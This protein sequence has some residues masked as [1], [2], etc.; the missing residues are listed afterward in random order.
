LNN[1]LTLSVTL[2]GDGRQLSGT[3]RDAQND[4][5]EFGTTTER[6]SRKA[7]T[8]LTAPGRSAV[9]VSDHLRTTQR[10]A[11]AFGTEATQGGREATQAL[12]QTSQQVQ[13]TNSHFN[14]LRT[15]VGLAL[16]AFSVR[17]LAGMADGWSDMQ[18][19]VGAAIGDMSAAGDMMERITDI[20]NASY[21]PLEQTAR[22][23]ASNVS[24][25]RDL[26]RTAADTADYTESLNHMLVLTA[27]RGQQA[28][29]VQNALSR[30]MAVGRLQADGLETVL[31]NGGEVA[32]SL[33]N[34]LGVTVSQLRGLASE[35]KITGDVIASALIGSLD[36]VRERAGEMPATIEDGFVRIGTSATRL[37][38]EL[39]QAMGASEGVAG[40]LIGAA[41]LMNAAIDPLV[42]NIDNI[43]FAATA[44]AVVLAGRYVGAIAASQAALAAKNAVVATTTGALNV[45]T[46]ATTRQAAAA[47]AMAGA[48]RVAA[49][50]LALIGG[51]LGAAVIA[52][53]AIYYF[54][55]ELGLVDVVAQNTTDALEENTAAI[56]SGTAAA[57]DA[58]YDN[59]INALE[60]VSLQA[61]D[62][63]AQMTELQARQA[64]YENSHKGMSDSVTGAIDQQAQS[65]AGLWEEQVRIQTAIRQ[66]RAERENATTADRAAAVA[67]DDITVSAARSTQTTNAATEAARA[68]AAATLALTK[69]TEA[70][71][72]A[73]EALRNRLVPNRRETLQ[74]AQ[75]QNTLNLAFAMG[76]ITA[77]EYLYMIGALQTAYIEAQNDADDLATSTTNAL[78]TMEGAMEELRTNGLRRLDDGF[79]DLW[80]GAVDGSRNATDTIRRMWDQT[81]AELLHM[82]ITRPITV[83]LATSMGLGGSGQQAASGS[84]SFG[85]LPSIRG[86]MNGS[87]AIANAYRAFQGTGSS[88]AGTFGSEL[89]V[90]TEGGLRAGFDSFVNSGFGNAALGIGGGIAGGYVGTQLGSSLFGRDAGSNYGAMGGAAL[91]QAFIPIPGLGAAIGGALGGLADSLFGSGKKTFDFDFL[92]GQ[93]SYVFGDRTS[94]FG[95]SGLTALSDYKLGEQQDQLNE[96]LTA[97]AEFDNQLAAAAIPERFE[98]MKASIHGFT[99][100]G[101]EDL[102]ETRLRTLIAGSESAMADA[103]VQI[104]DPQQLADTFV[105][106]LQL[107][108]IGQ[109]LGG[110]VLGDIE[111]EI[112]RQGTAQGV[113][114][115]AN[116]MA[117]AANAAA[118]LADSTDRLNLQFD[119]TA[120][121]AIHVASA[122]QAQFGGAENL[123]AVQSAYY[124]TAFSEAERLTHQQEALNAQFAALNMSMPAS[125]VQI[126]QLIEAQDMNTNAGA[127]L[128]YELM[129]LTPALDELTTAMARQNQAIWDNIEA[130]LNAEYQS[131]LGRTASADDL[132]YWMTQIEAG[133]V[134][135]DAALQMIANSTEAAGVAA[136]GGAAGIR[137]REQLE[138]QLLQA[139][140]N[141]AALRALELATLNPANHA[142]QRRIWAIQDEQAALQEA[143]RQQQR[144]A[145]ALTA[146][147]AQLVNFGANV[148]SWLAQLRGTDAGMGTPQQQLDAADA[149]FWAQYEKALAGDRNA[150]Q[151]ITSYADRYLQAGQGM[152]ASGAGAQ[153]IRDELI[154]VMERLPGLLSAEEFLAEEFKNTIGQQTDALAS[155]FDMLKDSIHRDLYANFENIDLNLDGLIDWSE[156]RRAFEGVASDDELRRIFDKLDTDGSRTISLA[157]AQR[158]LLSAMRGIS[159]DAEGSIRSVEDFLYRAGSPSWGLRVSMSHHQDIGAVRSFGWHA[160]NEIANMATGGAYL[161]KF[162]GPTTATTA[163]AART[164]GSTTGSGSTGGSSSGAGPSTPTDAYGNPLVSSAS[165]PVANAYRSVLGRD[166]DAAGLAYWEGRYAAGLS[167]AEIRAALRGEI[168]GSHFTGLWNVPFDGYV[169]ELHR[170]EMVV[171]AK[172]ASRLRDLPAHPPSVGAMP[173]PSYPQLGNNAVLET[174]RELKREVAELRRENAQLQGESNKHLAAANNQ[175]GAAAKG[176]IGAIERGNKMLKKMEDDK[177][178]E[179]AKR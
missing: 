173:L 51:P 41:D 134:S 75:N 138:R 23:Y 54:R 83:Q 21:A 139:Q 127:Q 32:Q 52:G 53:S 111:A 1:N 18:S 161:G 73:I 7:D 129:A 5:R 44:V 164:S 74:L 140:G 118:L 154:D 2:T 151:G 158:Q 30:A 137:E 68:A 103:V 78:Y 155:E 85:G 27:T 114:D 159:A 34:H 121:G 9:T 87:G 25:L 63:M 8:A 42:D 45:L 105:R 15:T 156:F 67:L 178:L 92:Q 66:N 43:Q 56:R 20:A 143:E 19:V 65:L 95:D 70:Q 57:L 141:T 81:L 12:S 108:Q 28:E 144:Y 16:G 157:E 133:A 26:G 109:Q 77:S 14:L 4:V 17:Q 131:T 82:A 94:A 24:A 175:R 165:G 113:N 130:S 172:T 166:P 3:L 153:S 101:P 35:G 160:A 148:N 89:A 142:L 76:R 80:L 60:A 126:R 39:D 169:A 58:S 163:A 50:A 48:T 167:L 49:G 116:A 119:V 90:Q 176:Q 93:H 171:P 96:M 64:F 91:G 112:N 102:F 84:Q 162:G 146:A 22:T 128:A 40:I 72:T 69:A 47:T 122:L 135:L 31:A 61:Q 37:V 6:E 117:V 13:T 174:L 177:R 38:G 132:Y 97:M 125:I 33:A 59:L 88:Y 150:L 104:A 145:Q 123:A 99:H 115:A 71:A 136:A 62:A 149:D 120:A 124:Q 179:V 86:M 55:E 36:D 110:A 10:E 46:G 79:A 106:V 147:Q 29:S 11:R 170:D 107:E 100:S 98:A 152:Y 168:D